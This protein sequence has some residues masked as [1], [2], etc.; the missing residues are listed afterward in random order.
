MKLLNRNFMDIKVKYTS[1]SFRQNGLYLAFLTGSC[2]GLKSWI[3]NCPTMIIDMDLVVSGKLTRRNGNMVLLCPTIIVGYQGNSHI[4]AELYRS[5]SRDIQQNS[6]DDDCYAVAEME[7]Q[8]QPNNAAVC[9][10]E[11]HRI[12]PDNLGFFECKFE[13]LLC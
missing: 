1:F 6:S 12:H 2:R 11:L 8:S 13:Q 7:S 3:T 10:L 9:K 5:I 4:I